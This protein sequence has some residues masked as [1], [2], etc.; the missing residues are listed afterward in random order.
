MTQLISRQQRFE[1]PPH[2]FV[3]SRGQKFDIHPVS[4]YLAQEQAAGIKEEWCERGEPVDPPTYTVKTSGGEE[5]TFP[6]AINEHGNTLDVKDN[7]E[8]TAAN[9]EAWRKHQDA[10]QRY[11][12][13]AN[14][15]AMQST[16]FEGLDVGNPPQEWVEKMK[17]HRVRLPPDKR[18][19][20]MKWIMTE[21]LPSMADWFE[22]LL[23]IQALSGTV[24]R[25]R[26]EAARD[27]FR[28]QLWGNAAGESEDQTGQ[29]VDAG[30][31]A[32]G[33]AGSES[34][35]QGTA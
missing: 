29:V 35:G 14:H 18:D 11:T 6:H 26:V 4:P 10:L 32:A 31:P 9:W 19:V 23:A 13:E 21:L 24:T 12:A 1:E 25:A 27:S 28:R 16:L 7:P 3:N 30:Q 34:V 5:Q 20:R 33:N 15:M 8:E 17:F 22:C 2:H